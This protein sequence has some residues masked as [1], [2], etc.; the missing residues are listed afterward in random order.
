MIFTLIQTWLIGTT[1]TVFL[2]AFFCHIGIQQWVRWKTL[3]I[4]PR[5]VFVA[6]SAKYRANVVF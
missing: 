4:V 2:K 1:C 5:K 6:K 3:G